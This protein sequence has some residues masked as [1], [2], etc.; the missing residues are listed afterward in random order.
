MR[1]RVFG[2]LMLLLAGAARLA[3]AA[4]PEVRVVLWF[5]TEDYLLPASDD[6]AKRVAEILTA[7]GIR[8]TFKVVGEKARV[9]EQRGRGDV[10]AA[11]RR[12]DIG[13]HSNLHSVHPTPAEYLSRCGWLDGVAEF[14]RRESAGAADV[15][16]IFG[17][18]ALSCYGQPG[19]SWGPQAH[20]ALKEIGVVTAAGV[21]VYLDEG[22]NVGFEERPFWY[23]GVLNVY[24]MGPNQTRMEL[25]EPGGLEKGCADFKAAYDRLRGEGGGLVSIYYHPAE[26]VHREFWDAVNFK[27]GANPPREEWKRPPQRPA[28]ETEAAFQRFEKYLDYQRSLPGVKHVTASDLPA[29][30]RNRIRE[31][32]ADLDAIRDVA[33]ALAR[34]AT[35]DVVRDRR[36]RPISPAEQFSIL[37]SFLARAVAEG[38]LPARVEAGDL[39]GPSERPPATESGELAWPAFRDALRDAADAARV[40]R[41]VPTCVFA[42]VKAIAPADFLRAEAAVASAVL[43][44]GPGPLAFPAAVAIPGG[45]AVATESHVAD[46]TPELFGGWIIHPEG[47]R[48]PRIVEMAKLQAWTLKPA[49]AATGADPPRADPPRGRRV[50]AGS[51]GGPRAGLTVEEKGARLELDCAHGT[52]GRTLTMDA[53]GA[54]EADGRYF[55][56]H[57][58]PTL[59]DDR[60]EG[61]AARYAGTLSGRTLSLTV[62]LGD[63]ETLGPYAL[64][65]GRPPR[66]MKCR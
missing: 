8:G 63:G 35:V 57:G 1:R 50:P 25:H 5:D 20:A 55:P 33:A 18:P 12:H 43:D 21:P 37:T 53:K 2:G 14:A 4:E 34:A 3:G 15:R 38:R 59:K 16:R 66:L 36:G 22:T 31:E 58:G 64:T 32:G 26:W 65:L 48:A 40:R 7:R 29:I 60:D 24:A 27:R 11:L 28:A 51:W 17:V 56:E 30:Y 47:F 52:I 23:A 13:Y 9:L 41:Q 61:R 42:G 46:D 6:A 45:T 44:A 49:E 39:L 62:K 19:S 10:V 54:F